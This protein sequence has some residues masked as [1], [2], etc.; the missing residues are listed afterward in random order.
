MTILLDGDLVNQKSIPVRPESNLWRGQGWFETMA[1]KDGVIFN[2]SDH[3]ERLTNSLPDDARA[4]TDWQRLQTQIA[5]LAQRTE[6]FARG[7]LVVWE[8]DCAY[9]YAGWTR[10]YEPPSPE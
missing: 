5:Q 8:E 3:I 1:I 6:G 9:R 10:P 7:K 4:E 2:V